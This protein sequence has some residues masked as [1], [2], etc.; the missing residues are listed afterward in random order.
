MSKYSIIELAAGVK[1]YQ[2]NRS[3]NGLQRELIG[4]SSAWLHHKGRNKHH[5]EYWVDFNRYGTVPSKMPIKYVVEMFCDRVAAT[6]IYNKDYDNKAP[7]DYYNAT[8]FYYI[9]EDSTDEILKDMLMFLANNNLDKT[10]K[11]IKEKYLNK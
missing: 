9:I 8:R 7:L 3:P 5:W 6:M 4:Y 2:G 10:I 1:Y 11:Y